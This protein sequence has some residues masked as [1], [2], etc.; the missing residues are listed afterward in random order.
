MPCKRQL[1]A[2]MAMSVVLAACSGGKVGTS[3][4]TTSPSAATTSS[5]PA[6][7]STTVAPSTTTAGPPLAGQPG[8]TT[9]ADLAFQSGYQET[10]VEAVGL[11]FIQ[12]YEPALNTPGTQVHCPAVVA[13]VGATFVC[14]VD[15]NANSSIDEPL[16]VDA[17]DPLKLEF[18]VIDPADFVCS[19]HATWVVDAMANAGM[20]CTTT[21]TTTQD[22]QGQGGQGQGGQGQ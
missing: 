2:A 5:N 10:A 21:P 1:M 17:I 16:K 22:G 8:A 9:R 4:T 14:L 19:A 12:D 15:A 20:P 3:A 11:S 7:S 13:S 18:A 6:A